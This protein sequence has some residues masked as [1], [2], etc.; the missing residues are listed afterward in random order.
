[1]LLDEPTTGLHGADV[2]RLVAALFRL[3]ARGHSVVVVEHNMEVAKAADWVI[4]LG[5]EGGDEGGRMV[6]AGPPEAVA[7]LD[8]PTGRALRAAFLGPP[9]LSEAGHGGADADAERGP[10]VIRIQGAREHN[11][12]HVEVDIPRERLVAVTGVSGSGKSTL[13]FDVLFAEG[14]RRFLDCLSTYVR[15]FIRPLARPEVDRVDG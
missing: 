1:V 4:D 10:E 13:A 8:T 11:L 14:Q 3:V 9:V 2:A 12:R 15:Q 6:G 7:R 5:P